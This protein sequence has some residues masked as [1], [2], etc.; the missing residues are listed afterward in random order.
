MR[1][2]KGILADEG[3][4]SKVGE[5]LQEVERRKLR[6]AETECREFEASIGQ[7]ERLRLEE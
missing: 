7:F 5:E 1:K 6:D 4:K 2:Q 3:F